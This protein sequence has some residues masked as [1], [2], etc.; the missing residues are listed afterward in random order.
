MATVTLS[1]TEFVN[2]TSKILNKYI[3]VSTLAV[4][5]PE[6]LMPYQVFINYDNEDLPIYQYE[7]VAGEVTIKVYEPAL[8]LPFLVNEHDETR[9]WQVIV[10]IQSPYSTMSK[11]I[12]DI[13]EEI[14]A[15]PDIT[16]RGEVTM[17]DSWEVDEYG[18]F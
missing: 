17:N 7:F 9:V 8:V 18:S 16:L 6:A 15:R 2:F 1:E 4:D 13:E 10:D 3:F 12:A 5:D 11:F 14:K